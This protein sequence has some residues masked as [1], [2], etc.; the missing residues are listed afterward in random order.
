VSPHRFIFEQPPS[1]IAI[2]NKKVLLFSPSA[3]VYF[4]SQTDNRGVVRCSR[5][6]N[7][8]QRRISPIVLD[9]QF[10]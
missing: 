2:Q 7:G 6:K 4:A 1:V 10:A 9:S 8:T 5:L 3:D